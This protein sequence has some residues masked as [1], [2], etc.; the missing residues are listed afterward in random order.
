ML[1]RWPFSLSFLLLLQTKAK[2]VT[3]SMYWWN[4]MGSVEHLMKKNNN[5]GQHM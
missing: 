4:K 2:L 3:R 5:K 1:E